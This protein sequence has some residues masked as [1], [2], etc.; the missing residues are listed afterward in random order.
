MMRQFGALL[1]SDDDDE[2]YVML[3]RAFLASDTLLKL[4]FLSDWIGILQSH[5]ETYLDQFHKEVD[6]DVRRMGIL[7]RPGDE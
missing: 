1:A 2:G 4:D 6:E 3:S 5:Y 7:P